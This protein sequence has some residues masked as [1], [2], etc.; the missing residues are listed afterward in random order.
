MAQLGLQASGGNGLYLVGIFDLSV[1]NTGLSIA[2]AAKLE[3]RVLGQTI[4]KLDAVGALLINDQGIAAKIG[5]TLGT[6]ASAGGV[7]FSFGGTFTLEL[8][9]TSRAI[10]EIGGITVSL[11]A[12]PY[13]RLSISGFVQFSLGPAAS[14]R[15]EGSFTIVGSSAGL[16]VAATAHLKAIVGGATLLDLSANGALLIGTSGIAAKIS[17]GASFGSSSTFLFTGSLVFELNTTGR[18]IGSIAGQQ[19]DL[20]AGSYVRI[21]IAGSL[22]L[23]DG[24]LTAN[25]SF[26]L[27]VGSNG[28]NIAVT[29]KLRVF[30]VSF[31]LNATIIINSSGLVFKSQLSLSTASAF[32]PFNGL[33]I[34]GT[35]M[36][37]VNTTGSP[38]LGIPARTVRVTISGGLNILGI[39]LSGSFII[40]VSATGFRLEIPQSAPIT[41]S[42]LGIF[43]ISLYGYI[44][45]QGFSFTGSAGIYLTLGPAYLNVSGSLTLSSS[46]FSFHVHGAAGIQIGPITTPAVRACAFGHCVTIIP[47]VTL[48]PVDVGISVDAEVTLTGNALSVT[49]SGSALG[50]TV[51][52]TF[53]LGH[54][55]PP[56]AAQVDRTPEPVL[57]SR[58]SDGTLRLN[59]GTYASAR[60]VAGFLEDGNENF[61]VLHSGGSR[62]S[63]SLFV[64]AF[65]FQQ[66]F[67]G[68]LRI[69]VIDAGNGVDYLQIESGVLSDAE[70][71]GGIGDDSLFY[72][73]SGSAL[74]DGGDG[75]DV[76]TVAGGPGSTL[77]GGLGTDS[78]TG[79][80]GNDTLLGGSGDDTMVGGGGN[81]IL[82]GGAGAD[83][84]NGGDGNDEFRWQ[85]SDGVDFEIDGGGN[86]GDILKITLTNGADTVQFDPSTSDNGFSLNLSGTTLTAVNME[87][88]D[89]DVSGA[90]DFIT[91][92]DLT[93]S[94]L[95]SITLRLGADAATD[96]ITVNGSTSTD[97][98]TTSV[99]SGVLNVSRSGGASVN[100][101]QAGN[102]NGGATL[103]LNLNG[104]AD[105][106]TVQQTLVGVTTTINGGAGNDT[107]SV[108]PAG[109]V[110]GIAGILLVNGDSDSDTLTVDDKDEAGAE[111]G[112]LTASRIWGFGMPGSS[113]ANNGI[114]Y[115]GIEN[116]SLRL[117]ARADTVNVL[118]TNASTVSTIETGAGTSANTVNVGSTAPATEG[119]L[120]AIA[121]KLVIIGQSNTDTVNLYDKDNDGAEVGFLTSNRVWGFDMP[122]SDVSNGGVTYSGLEALNILL[123]VRG[124]TMNVR[125][126]ASGTTTTIETGAG[127]ANTVNINSNAPGNSG[128]LNAIAGQVVVV[129]QSSDDTLNV[130]D[131]DDDGAETGFLSASRIWGFDMPGSSESGGGV[132]YSNV[133]TLTLRLGSR[134]DTLNVLST[135]AT[136]LTTVETGTGSAPNTVHV[137]SAAPI[138]LNGVLGKLVINGQSSDDTVTVDDSGDVSANTGL[139]TSN[140][141]IGLGMGD[142]SAAS[143]TTT[144]RLSILISASAATR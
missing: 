65:G 82:V 30:A 144:L 101:Q 22:S 54:L 81:D 46:G 130:D 71:H 97:A 98:Y 99:S 3:A 114:T 55:D 41:F 34:F 131:K 76:L 127:T 58:L 74:L 42:F 136:T 38:S 1:G 80:T 17:V 5:L 49:V 56:G 44:S 13:A 84:M 9:T 72:F 29:A 60:A 121:G 10:A 4:L 64:N 21:R 61:T 133:E 120:N 43:N 57:A 116:V 88:A 69:L 93:G 7:G 117:G 89:I 68:I 90:S 132:T 128:N 63:E 119:N 92:N 85:P 11:L 86:A 24:L 102:S 53:S 14:F 12:G 118:N 59:M 109:N 96:S 100:I 26:V 31:N 137:G 36:L 35:F 139:V 79:G 33:E 23:I 37:E 107:V 83:D 106:V 111:T 70:I 122:G 6:G 19:V 87:A 16:E 75:N 126:T 40:T 45:N 91:I 140:R 51:S 124:D 39:K 123:G 138:T 28:L 8:N 48:G 143:S 62:G 95:T 110:D 105:S 77:T 15:M 52:K 20:A 135:A 125:S 27:E 32:I 73:G 78:I 47:S 103:T 115:N 113:A 25:G 94:T 134:A 112:F 2:A 142:P 50:I 67:T 18:Y 66:Q 129:G 141:V 104:G 108:S